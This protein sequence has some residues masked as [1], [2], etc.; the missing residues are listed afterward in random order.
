MGFDSDMMVGEVGIYTYNHIYMYII[1]LSIS[2]DD[3]RYQCYNEDTHL[4]TWQEASDPMHKVQEVPR[5]D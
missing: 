1:Q 2:C 3:N 4:P 5:V